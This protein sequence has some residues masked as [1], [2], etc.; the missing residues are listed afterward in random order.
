MV[1]AHGLLLNAAI[2]AR[3]LNG[4]GRLDLVVSGGQSVFVLTGRGDG[5]FEVTWSGAAGENPVDLA[6]ADLDETGLADLAATGD[7]DGDGRLDFA[8]ANDA[9]DY[10]S[11]FLTR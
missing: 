9:A 10:V 7:F 4:D 5:R 11:V 6:I 3:D 1:R 2:Q 8:V